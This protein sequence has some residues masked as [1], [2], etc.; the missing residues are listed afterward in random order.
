[1]GAIA[2]SSAFRA[3]TITTSPIGPPR[4]TSSTPI[5]R[6]GMGATAPIAMRKSSILPSL[7]LPTP[8]M[9]TFEIACAFR[10]PVFRP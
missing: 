1:M 5:S 9:H 3:F 7:A 4:T 2:A 10:A 6:S 8:A